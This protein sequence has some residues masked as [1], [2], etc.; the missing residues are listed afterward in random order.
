MSGSGISLN[1]KACAMVREMA[2]RAPELRIGVSTLSNGARRIDAGIHTEGSLEAG[3]RISEICLGG[4]GTVE[5]TPWEHGDIW[6]P[7]VSV[8]VSQPVLGCLASQLAGWPVQDGDFYG[9]GSGPARAIAAD[10]AV[11]QQI[12]Y[13]DAQA[14]GAVL[15]L[16]TDRLPDA[17][18]AGA[19]AERCR[20]DPE[21]LWLIAAPTGSLVGSVQIAARIV[22]TGMHKLWELGYAVHDVLSGYGICPVAPLTGD[23]LVALGRVNDCILYGGTVYLDVRGDEGDIRELLD[24]IPSCASRDCGRSFLELFEESGRDFYAMD[25]LL[26]SPARVVIN[27]V[28]SG[29][30]YSAGTV[31]AEVLRS[32]LGWEEPD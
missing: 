1:E 32:S 4:M 22:E 20:I 24:R 7:G 18:T 29:K 10:D 9:M 14:T 8:A 21:R 6:L 15:F 23:P 11:F 30:T 2:A 19:V 17:G 28:P 27:H 26:F 3:R 5:M 25:P 12:G 31:R 13:R 16:E